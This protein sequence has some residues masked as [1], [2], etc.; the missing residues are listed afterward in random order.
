MPPSSSQPSSQPEAGASTDEK[1]TLPWAAIPRYVPGVTDTTEYAK[2]LKFLSEVWPKEHLSALGPRVALLCE[3][4]AFKKISRLDAAKLKAN[5]T[6]GVQLIVTTLGGA[7]GQTILEE[8]YEQFERAIYSTVQRND[9]TH[10][11]Y[12]ARHDIHFEEL[13]A[14]NISFEELRSYVLLRQSQLS[15]EDKKR[16]VIEHSGKLTYDKVKASIRLLGSRFFGE[17]QGQ[18]SSQRNKVY[19]ANT[20][21]EDSTDEPEKAFQAT[22]SPSI[23]AV[24]EN[25][26]ELEPEYLEAMVASEDQD[27]LQVQ[28][29]EEELEGFFQETPDLQ[30]ALVSYFEARNRLL[31]KKKSRG[32]WPISGA[33]QSSKGGRPFKGGKSGKGKGKNSREQLL[34]RI[35]RSV[36]RACGERGHWKAE[37]PKFGRPGSMSGKG[38]AATTTVTEV[39]EETAANAASGSQAAAVLT[40]VPEDAI[41]L[42]EANVAICLDQREHVLG[43]L[44][45]VA[46]NL[47]A[48]AAQPKHVQNRQR[49]AGKASSTEGPGSLKASTNMQPQL[50]IPRSSFRPP[51]AVA[52]VLNE[53]VRAILDTGASR[54]VMGKR[55]LSSFVS[56]LSD[57]TRAMIK[58]T[59][60][61]VKFRFGNNQTLTSELRVLL[62]FRAAHQQVLWLSIEIVPGG[63]PLL[64]S[65]K[66]IKQ[67]G[68]VIDTCEDVC[69]LKCLQKSLRLSTGPTGLYMID[70]A[71]LCEESGQEQMCHHASE[72]RPEP[73]F[74]TDLEGMSLE[75]MGDLVI[76]FGKAMK[77]KRY[78]D[79]IQNEGDWVK[80]FIDHYKSSGKH[81]HKAFLTYVEKY[82]SQAEQIE[83]ELLH[84]EGASEPAPK[85]VA[86][87]PK[88]K[89]APRRTLAASSNQAQVDQWD[90]LSVSGET[91]P[92]LDN[93][94]SALATRMTHIEHVMEQMLCA[95]Q[96]MQSP[97]PAQATPNMS[98]S[99]TLQTVEP[100]ARE[101]LHSEA[102]ATRLKEFLDQVPWH[103][104]RSRFSPVRGTVQPSC[105]G[106]GKPTAY[107]VFGTYIHGGVVG[108]TR[109]TMKFPWLTRVLARLMQLTDPR[110]RFTS[111]GIACNSLS[112]PHR[113]QYNSSKHPNLVV[114]VKVPSKGGEVWVAR[115]SDDEPQATQTMSCSGKQVQ[116]F[117]RSIGQGSLKLDPHVWH[118]T[119]PWRGD[120]TV[121]IGYSLKHAYKLRTGQVGWL[122]RHGFAFP[123]RVNFGKESTLVA[124]EACESR[125]PE[126]LSEDVPL[127][128]AA[129]RAAHACAEAVLRAEE[130]H[131]QSQLMW[132]SPNVPLLDL[133][134]IHASPDSRL[135]SEINRCGGSARRFTTLDGD[136]ATEQGQ[137]CLWDLVKRT[138]PKHIWISPESRCWSSW[139]ALNAARSTQHHAR[140]LKDREASQAQLRLCVQLCDWQRRHLRDFHMELPGQIKVR[141]MSTLRPLVDKT[142]RSQVD[143]CAFG[144]QSPVSRQ[145]IR[146][147]IQ[148]FSTSRDMFKSLQGKICPEDHVHQ[149]LSGRVL[150]GVPLS[151]FAGTYCHG[152]AEHVAAVIVSG[153]AFPAL[154][155]ESGIPAT[156]KR[157]KTSLGSPAP[158]VRIEPQK[159]VHENSLD[160]SQP[161]ES[162]RRCSSVVHAMS[163]LPEATW[164]PVFTSA[165]NLTTK[166]TVLIPPESE[167]ARKLQQVLENVNVLQA[168]VGRKVRNLQHPLGA[169]PPTVAPMRLSLGLRTT[170]DNQVKLLCLGNEDR[171]T[172]LAERKKMRIEP[173]DTLLTIFGK[174][175][176]S[177][178][179]PQ[180]NVAGDTQASSSIRSSEGCVPQAGS[181]PD[182][183]G[184]A[185]PPIPIHGPA[186]RNLSKEDRSQLI[187]IHN[188]LGHPAPTTLA[189]HLK[190]AGEKPAMVEAALDYQC[191]ACLEATEPRH[192]RPSK[193]PEALEFNDLIGVDGFFFKSKSGFRAY[194]LHALD[195]ASC[196][197]LGR[198]ALTRGTTHATSALS[199]FWLSW[200]GN[201]RRVYLDP[202]GEFRSEEILEYFQGLNIKTFVTAAAW[203]RGKLER[204]G[205][206]IKDMLSRLDTHSPLAN[207]DLFDQALL[208]AFQAKNALVRHQGYAPE[209]IV[210]GKSLRIPG[211]ITSDD[212]L[213]SHLLV[214]GEDLEAERHR[215]R[216]EL[217]CRARQ[218]F[219]DSDNSQTI[220]RALLRRSNPVRGPYKPGD[221]VLYWMRKGSPNRL[222]AGR[223]HGPARV[224]SQEGSSIT[225]VS[226]GTIILRCAP[227]NLRPASLREWQQLSAADAELPSK[228]AGGAN[229]YVDLTSL[230]T[231]SAQL[232]PSTQ[233]QSSGEV[234]VPIPSPAV[235]RPTPADDD[236]IA[237][238]EQELTPQVSHNPEGTDSGREVERESSVP[239]GPAAPSQIP[240][241]VPIVVPGAPASMSDAPSTAPADA[242]N[243]PIPEDEDD[244]LLA[245][246]IF[247]ASSPLGAS[248]DDDLGLTTFTTLQTSACASGP[249]LAE[250]NLPFVEQPL[251]C[252]EH[253]AYCL[254]IPVRAKDLKKWAK[255]TAP[256]QLTLL[257][258]IGKR[259]RAEVHVKDLS[260]AEQILFEEA[261][262]KELQCWIQTSAI[263]SILRKQLNPEQILKSRW[264]LTWKNPE[265]GETQRRAKARLVVLGY[266]DPK[267]TD[268]VRD[269]PTL[270]KEGRALVLQ[271]IASSRFEL[272]SFDIKTAFLRG[273]A[274]EQNPLAME[275]P[276]ELRKEL[277]MSDEEVCQLLGNAYGRVDAP[278]LFYKELSKQ[279]RELGF[280][281]HPLE[282]CVFLLYTEGVLNGILG[283][284]VDDGVCGGDSKFTQKIQALQTKLPFGSRKFRNFIFT[285][286]HLEQFPDYSIRA[287]QGEY[288]RNIPQIDIGRSRRV[289]P[290]AL[291]TESERSK[292]RG[293]VGSLQYAVTHTR[294]D[295]A[296]K[297]GELQGQ[298]TQASVQTLLQ[299]NKV[300]RET[301][302]QEQVSIHFLPIP[303]KDITFVSFGDAS[304]ASSKNLNSHQGAL[305][306]ATDSRLNQNREAPLSPLTWTSKKIPRVVRST[307]SAEA[308]AMSKA[309]DMLGWMRALWGVVHVPTFKWQQPEEGFKKL[310]TA[311]IVTDCK[312]L[313]DLVTR[314]AMPACEE[315]RTTLEVL[316]IKQRCA[317]NACFRWIPTTLQAADCLT[318]VMDA[319]LLRT[320]LSQ[321]R[322]KL[323]DTSKVLE[324]DAQRRQA[325][326]WL[327]EPPASEES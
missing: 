125:F 255:E 146:K 20:L 324:K 30:E 216:L 71:R 175:K 67:L 147:R 141:D 59:K 254:E 314:L 212:D 156:R 144:L 220:R 18:R 272:S 261:K 108:I 149:P 95:I 10:D 232:M 105:Q 323:F 43:S 193:L 292:L 16:I 190:A 229:T 185:P 310:N 194:V 32:F 289:N 179:V 86:G 298:I 4:T 109:V 133:L 39:I 9:E 89:A 281:Q 143:M 161:S 240:E 234:M 164:M 302:E 206:I 145:P 6:S 123:S 177:P 42:A 191:D 237:Q 276:K 239:P 94:V 297:L 258:S 69:H 88:P 320:V 128:Q 99:V 60:S 65:K 192:Q 75:R 112:C 285:G 197:H 157:F 265:P 92:A 313:F 215:K 288:V 7:W 169:L 246:N 136:L 49:N 218:V 167:A 79:V 283:V 295:M 70:L 264:I 101:L 87:R 120:R 12:L 24:E 158:V 322:F 174:S 270:S 44:R 210:L 160:D 137:Q 273:K 184:W 170:A 13:L 217:R 52:Y 104:I 11:S 14:Q 198:R 22:A 1:S 80:W 127:K 306:C 15:S 260:R 236:E 150:K 25:E 291:V 159:R 34:A 100:R 219:W 66:A 317:E 241:S 122:R 142:I 111:I 17:M 114:P 222:A 226:H 296:A 286:I 275:P 231:I 56:Q 319:T 40:T 316:L 243:V 57:A 106:S 83:K 168:F 181:L 268:V 263:K 244:G 188:N 257:A 26:Y 116:G 247:L 303:P 248:D 235:P 321:G 312:S 326:Q 294:P 31:A 74:S 33:G 93:Q 103:A 250:D 119:M 139:S 307:L 21:E 36:C 225:W 195:E 61:A 77:G 107:V 205:D 117:L 327:S 55:L 28:A 115:T 203:Q 97:P 64:F 299:A 41:P 293:L 173:Q 140:M 45:R 271:T 208:Q 76:D 73:H 48:R 304:F 68:G 211:S 238:P 78:E 262:A 204:H 277:G 287:S 3:G 300:L 233:L 187:R 180:S 27:A 82:V 267:L 251:T 124:N 63:T 207:D 249:P 278:L 280:I 35:A 8:K 199:D 126:P 269:A 252:S 84:D 96:Q 90:L 46:A 223:W 290:E 5:D 131:R 228:N 98:G 166:G 102:S 113:D 153:N 154:A 284:H 309:V 85:A 155:V 38:E 91:E 29:F 152:F 227:E 135:T 172:M 81:A 266:Q 325:I 23:P 209:Q 176:D 214:E 47:K 151:Q 2:K 50:R 54:C 163:E 138:Q 311:V 305:V 132:S 189:K 182:M 200:A 224:I 37:C 148:V 221:W 201:P 279:L 202:A 58:V 282:P 196:F 253:Q 118:A 245:E 51:N 186:F 178:D 165:A 53:P 259:A 162:K 301:Q 242:S 318:K 315:H 256:E 130:V 134:E 230:N 121:A 171:T 72:D 129:V 308:Y 62:P 274:D 213:A 110:H 183:Q 19:D